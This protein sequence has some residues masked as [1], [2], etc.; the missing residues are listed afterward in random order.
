MVPG[1]SCARNSKGMKK[2]RFVVSLMVAENDYQQLQAASA[3]EAARHL[4]SDID[5][6]YADNDAVA[7]GQQLL[8]VIQSTA[9]RPDG[10]ICH[11]VGTSLAQVG[12]Q[13]A[14]A[15]LGWSILNREADYLSELRNTFGVPMFL[16]SVDQ[17]E[18]GRI[19]G[20]QF[21]ALLPQGGLGLYITGPGTNPAFKMRSEGMESTKPANIQLR[22]LAGKLTE[23]SGYDV[24]LQWLSLSTSRDS[25]IQLVAAQNDN[26]AMGARKAFIE[27]ATGATRERWSKLRYAGCDGCP[28]QGEKWVRE[29]S[30]HASVVLPP[31]AGRALQMMARAIETSEQPPER[32]DLPPRALPELE[33]LAAIAQQKSTAL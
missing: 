5:I 15:G 28:G 14:L 1:S 11:P 16:V 6:I 17:R 20:R 27:K 19:Q 21:G 33:K 4:G 3:R 30:L 29:G 9:R 13:A 22:T 31:S 32:T 8:E 25:P 10:I 18:I 26:M 24:I 23:Q 12:R 2:L 7:Q